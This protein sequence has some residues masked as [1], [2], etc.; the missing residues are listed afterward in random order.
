MVLSLISFVS[1][2]S[3][4]MMALT[5]VFWSSAS[6]IV[7]ELSKPIRSIWRLRILTHIEWKVDT[8]TPSAPSP[9]M[10]STRLR[11]SPA[12]LLVKVIARIFHGDTPHSSIK[13]AI[14]CTSTLV[15]PEPAPASTSSGPSVVITASLWQSFN[16]S[17]NP[18]FFLTKLD[19]PIFT[20]GG[21]DN[22]Y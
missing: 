1:I 18:T 4:F 14:L 19:H 13:Y 16:E 3:F 21:P 11:I 12:A 6:Y 22:T 17:N 5:T 7:N 9:T 10:A 8:H 2:L 20:S 15:L